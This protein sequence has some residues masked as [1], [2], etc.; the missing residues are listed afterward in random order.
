MEKNHRLLI[1]KL[2]RASMAVI[3]GGSFAVILELLGSGKEMG[4]WSLLIS[5][6]CSSITLP[7]AAYSFMHLQGFMTIKQPPSQSGWPGILALL[8]F[9]VGIGGVIFHLSSIAGYVFAGIVALLVFM[10][11]NLPPEPF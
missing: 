10:G 5:L 8:L 1:F 7:L 3:A 11:P 2:D 6:I 9:P 4:D